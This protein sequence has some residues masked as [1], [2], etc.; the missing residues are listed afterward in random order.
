MSRVPAQD[1]SLLGLSRTIEVTVTTIYVTK[2]VE[3]IV[4]NVKIKEID[5]L[6]VLCKCTE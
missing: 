6:N 3:E 1:C 2:F 5:M 4:T